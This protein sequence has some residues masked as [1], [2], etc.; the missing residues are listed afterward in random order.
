MDEEPIE[1]ACREAIARFRDA[2]GDLL[3]PGDLLVVN[4]TRVVPARLLGY[5][6]TGGKV[7]V[8][9]VRRLPGDAETWVCMTKSSKPPR[10]GSR[11]VLAGE[12]EAEVVELRHI[13]KHTPSYNRRSRPPR[14]QTWVKLTT[15]RFPRL[16]MVRSVKDDGGLYLGPFGS[17][18]SAEVVV[19][20][21]W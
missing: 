14:S 9:P 18:K 10:A 1:D 12:L 15:E 16:S 6:A 11:L 4:D 3:R 5:K 7:E 8:L 17:R 21:I 13:A 2:L 19:H 20:A